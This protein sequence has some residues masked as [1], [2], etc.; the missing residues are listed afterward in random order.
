V[1]NKEYKVITSNTPMFGNTAKLKQILAEE[2]DQGWDLVELIDPNKI[3]VGRDKSARVND[4]S[5][6]IDPYRIQVGINSAIYLGVAAVVTLVLIYAIIQAA[7][8]S[9]G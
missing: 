8:L 9:V 4:G 1:D 6:K 3:R 5:A 2:A 7:A